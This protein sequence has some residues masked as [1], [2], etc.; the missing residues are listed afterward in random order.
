[1]NLVDDGEG[2]WILS[3]IWTLFLSAYYE[4]VIWSNSLSIFDEGSSIL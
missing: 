4:G 1:M 2:H 3:P